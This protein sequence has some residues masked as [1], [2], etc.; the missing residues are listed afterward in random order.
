IKIKLIKN[1]IFKKIVKFIYNNIICRYSVFNHIKLD[2]KFE[3][4]RIV[5]KKLNKLEIKRIIIFVYN[6][7][8]NRIIERKY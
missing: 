3:F 8:V 4:K 6:S 1:S 5:I 7:K 2:K